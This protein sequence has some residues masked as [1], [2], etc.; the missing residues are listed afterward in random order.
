LG[1]AVSQIN[2]MTAA[3]P[4]MTDNSI[5]LGSVLMLKKPA[6]MAAT[7]P[8][9]NLPTYHCDPNQKR[10]GATVGQEISGDDNRQK[11]T[12]RKE[13]EKQKATLVAANQLVITLSAAPTTCQLGNQSLSVWMCHNV[14]SGLTTKLNDAA[15]GTPRLQP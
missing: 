2:A 12:G 5:T 1:C 10:L 8:E 14:C 11:D 13:C 9:V 6:D 7:Q 15:H 3:A 4:K